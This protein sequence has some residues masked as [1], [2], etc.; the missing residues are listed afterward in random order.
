MKFIELLA[1][2]WSFVRILRLVMGGYIAV[3][4]LMEGQHFLVL[5]GLFFVYQ[6]VMNVGCAACTPIKSEH[7]NLETKNIEVEYEEV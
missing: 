1:Q 4:S 2:P 7:E 3:V 6:A 5:A